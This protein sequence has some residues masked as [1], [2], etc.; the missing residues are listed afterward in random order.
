MEI[1]SSS[2]GPLIRVPIV[3]IRINLEVE[4][5]GKWNFCLT[6]NGSSNNN[7]VH[8]KSLW[9]HIIVFL[10]VLL[11]IYTVLHFELLLWRTTHI[12]HNLYLE[13]KA[14]LFYLEDSIC[15][16]GFYLVTETIYTS[17]INILNSLRVPICTLII[18]I[19]NL[20]LFIYFY[21]I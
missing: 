14:M 8:V 17:Q 18:K 2:V 16:L 6:N 19:R 1:G 12:L 9:H 15:M 7:Y 21:L 11:C 20:S 13:F 4:D 5:L 10:I 3:I